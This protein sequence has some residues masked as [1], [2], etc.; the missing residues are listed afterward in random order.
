MKGKHKALPEITAIKAFIH[1]WQKTLI[2]K[3]H[4]YSLN[5]RQK[6]NFY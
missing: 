6:R 2:N 5:F 3:K 1:G 4:L